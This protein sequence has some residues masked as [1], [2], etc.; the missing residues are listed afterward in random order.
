MKRAFL[1][2]LLAGLLLGVW[3]RGY[4]PVSVEPAPSTEGPVSH[5]TLRPEAAEPASPLPPPPP[6]PPSS[7]AGLGV[8]SPRLVSPERGTLSLDGLALTRQE[9]A[10]IGQIMQAAQKEREAVECRHL[11]QVSDTPG[12]QVYEISPHDAETQSIREAFR[13]QL[14]GILGP[15]RAE[16]VARVLENEMFTAG[17]DS[18]GEARILTV[19]TNDQGMVT[20]RESVKT[21]GGTRVRSQSSRG[22]VPAGYRHLFEP[23]P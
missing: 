21:H 23:V 7:P 22:S 18:G 17:E 2:G 5:P 3:V 4:W 16:G 12:R 6:E 15:E 8:S 20:V 10:H 19:E 11:R 1:P 14:N 13:T 9:R